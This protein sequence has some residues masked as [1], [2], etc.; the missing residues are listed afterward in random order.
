VASGRT[1]VVDLFRARHPGT[2]ETL[3]LG[4]DRGASKMKGPERTQTLFIKHHRLNAMTCTLLSRLFT[5]IDHS[6]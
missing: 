3:N 4:L 6:F 2:L 5:F 1:G